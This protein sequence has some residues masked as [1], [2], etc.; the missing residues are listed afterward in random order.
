MENGRLALVEAQISEIRCK[1]SI[2]VSVLAK[3]KSSLRLQEKEGDKNVGVVIREGNFALKAGGQQKMSN[4]VF[5]RVIRGVV[6]N[7]F[8]KTSKKCRYLF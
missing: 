8:K 2:A 3:E 7:Y 4:G 5:C 1:G 6:L